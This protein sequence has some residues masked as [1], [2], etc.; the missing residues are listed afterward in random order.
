MSD[1]QWKRAR[2]WHWQWRWVDI[3]SVEYVLSLTHIFCTLMCILKA[4]R[5]KLTEPTSFSTRWE[6]KLTYESHANKCHKNVMQMNFVF[7]FSVY[8]WKNQYIIISK[9][10]NF[11]FTYKPHPI[12]IQS[13]VLLI[14]Q[15]KT[16]GICDHFPI[17][18]YI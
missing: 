17:F 14:L 15:N 6:L 13:S 11:R 5:R 16:T 10:I 8:K 9:H 12:K 1:R 4:P 7:E 3:N 2:L 18:N